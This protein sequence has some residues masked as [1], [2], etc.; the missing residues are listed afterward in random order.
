VQR[1][2]GHKRLQF[3]EDGG[4]KLEPP[5]C[6]AAVEFAVFIEVHVEDVQT[7]PAKLAV[8]DERLELDPAVTDGNVPELKF[9]IHKVHGERRRRDA[10]PN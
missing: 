9:S 6:I 4:Q 5:Q 7:I 8:K 10:K 3:F 1:K 2:T